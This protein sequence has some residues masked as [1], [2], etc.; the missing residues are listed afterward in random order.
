MSE[1]DERFV[2]VNHAALSR[3]PRR[4]NDVLC[5]GR[6]R[7]CDRIG[8]TRSSCSHEADETTSSNAQVRVSAHPCSLSD[9]DQRCFGLL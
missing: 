4:S 9:R 6:P 5:D 8:S 1:L 3:L 7:F 2:L